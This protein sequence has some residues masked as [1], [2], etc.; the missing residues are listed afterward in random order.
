MLLKTNSSSDGIFGREFPFDVFWMKSKFFK[1]KFTKPFN[2][3]RYTSSIISEHVSRRQGEIT[4]QIW[5]HREVSMSSLLDY[6]KAYLTSQRRW[7]T[8]PGYIFISHSQGFTLPAT[9]ALVEL[10]RCLTLYGFI[11]RR[12]SV[13]LLSLFQDAATDCRSTFVTY[14]LTREQGKVSYTVS[15]ASTQKYRVLICNRKYGVIALN[16]AVLPSNQR[17]FFSFKREKSYT[18]TILFYVKRLEVFT[19]ISTAGFSFIKLCYLSCRDNY[20][21]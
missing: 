4:E 13:L 12:Q 9:L 15:C 7:G 6:W 16:F 8:L 14:M 17:L 20:Y 11:S 2:S 18:I 1:W 19:D 3:L 5:L 10:L 21:P